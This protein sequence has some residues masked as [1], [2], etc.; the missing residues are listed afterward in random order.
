MGTE[1][2][3]AQ[4]FIDSISCP[5]TG[6]SKKSSPASPAPFA[7]VIAFVGLY[8]WFASAET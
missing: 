2:T 1:Q 5:L 3:A 4:F 7:N 8:P 6:C